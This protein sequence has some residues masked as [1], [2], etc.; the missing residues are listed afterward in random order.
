MEYLQIMLGSGVFAAI[1]SGMVSVLIAKKSNS[2]QYV[3]AERK[4]WREEIRGIVDG[5]GRSNN[6]DE[7]APYLTE[8]ESRINAYGYFEENNYMH[9]AHIWKLITK[10]M[11]DNHAEK[12]K[13]LKY[14]DLLV[15]F[16]ALLLKHDWERAKKE[17]KG[18]VYN[19]A[20]MVMMIMSSVFYSIAL[21]SK[22]V[23]QHSLLSIIVFS[24]F[25]IS[26]FAILNFYFL[27]GF[28]NH[29]KKRIWKYIWN[30]ISG[31]ILLGVILYMSNTMKNLLDPLPFLT[32]M[33]FYTMFLV[34]FLISEAYNEVDDINYEKCIRKLCEINQDIMI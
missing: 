24:V 5:V 31:I 14:K 28:M 9:D 30:G 34:M 23:A 6:R 10:I 13:F 4:V 25:M 17:V 27:F 22:N 21:L 26:I 20:M 1:I 16:L 3:T 18:N 29:L 33:V 32:S 19:V 8:L 2:L 12:G 11:N 7:I 15:K